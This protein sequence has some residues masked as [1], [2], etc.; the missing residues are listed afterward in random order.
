[1]N[2][3][4][5]AYHNLC[6]YTMAHGHPSFIHQ[7][8]VDAFAAQD[9]KEGDKPIRL[10]FALVGLYLHVEKGFTGRQVQLA[11]MALARKKRQWPAFR[12]PDDRGAMNAANALAA[13]PGAE[14]DQVIHDWSACV[15]RAFSDNRQ[16]I[17]NLLKDYGIS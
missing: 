14:R 10:T 1:M 3:D 4:E 5:E 7:H 2:A 12:I 9:A 13:N 15:W 16:T 11:H 17:E 6:C 8:V